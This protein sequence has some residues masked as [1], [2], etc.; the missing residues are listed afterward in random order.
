MANIDWLIEYDDR[1]KCV[2]ISSVQKY[3]QTYGLTL[4]CE[5]PFSDIVLPRIFEM[6]TQSICIVFHD[7]RCYSCS[8]YESKYTSTT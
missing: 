3:A 7:G 1:M 6:K 2:Y 4:Y 5:I 8:L